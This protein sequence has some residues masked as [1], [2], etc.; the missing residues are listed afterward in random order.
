M[1][2]FIICVFLYLNNISY[3]AEIL[4]FVSIN[5][6]NYLF[7][8]ISPQEYTFFIHKKCEGLSIAK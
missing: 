1:I 5:S 4:L 6:K 3:I 7:S 8:Y 2:Y